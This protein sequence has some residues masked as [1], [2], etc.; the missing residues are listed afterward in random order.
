VL[1]GFTSDS[2]IIS[3]TGI[4]EVDIEL[5]PAGFENGKK[6]WTD[7]GAPFQ[8]NDTV[9]AVV[10]LPGIP[11]IT[12]DQ[13]QVLRIV[14]NSYEFIAYCES[15]ADSPVGLD[16]TVSELSPPSGDPIVSASG[17]GAPAAPSNAAGSGSV[18]APAAPTAIQ[19]GGLPSAP[20]APVNAAGAGTVS[21]PAAP[22][23]IQSAGMP[24][25]PTAPV[26]A[27]GVGTISAPTAPSSIQAGGL[28]AAPTA[29]VNAAGAG[30]VSAPAAPSSIQ[31][32]GLPAAPAAPSPVQP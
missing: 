11:S 20:T 7:D 13:W 24:G 25:A 16:F 10:F 8:G 28:P 15:S 22:T 19:P 32:G 23:A 6:S 4:E 31:A 3:G 17:S 30:T 27:A 12:V 1:P 14:S 9:T 29:P 26:N 2:I 21:G 5:L 18:S